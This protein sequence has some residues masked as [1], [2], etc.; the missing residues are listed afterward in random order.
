MVFI[1]GILVG[2]MVSETNTLRIVDL[3]VPR[4]EI[5]GLVVVGGKGFWD[6]IVACLVVAI[7]GVDGLGT[8]GWM[9]KA[10]G[11]KLGNTGGVG[12]IGL[13]GVLVL[14]SSSGMDFEETF[15]EIEAGLW[16]AFSSF[17]IICSIPSSL[18]VMKS[19]DNALSKTILLDRDLPVLGFVSD[20]VGDTST[21]GVLEFPSATLLKDD[22]VWPNNEAE[23]SDDWALANETNLG[24]ALPPLTV[25]DSLLLFSV[26]LLLTNLSDL[27]KSE[28][29]FSKTIF[30]GKDSTGRDLGLDVKLA[31]GRTV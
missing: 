14:G 25:G 9:L 3:E 19:S 8:A 22:V 30:L 28:S 2:L 17:L 31:V 16:R 21:K 26:R 27:T 24:K 5:G 11:I 4:V 20:T 6:N 23:D 29:A 7:L 18:E 12:L 15:S 13:L 1:T 10:F